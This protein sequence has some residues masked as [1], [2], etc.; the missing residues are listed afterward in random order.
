MFENNKHE[1]VNTEEGKM[2][3]EEKD[4]RESFEIRIPE[5]FDEFDQDDLFWAIP[6]LSVA[7]SSNKA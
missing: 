4:R 7:E 1:A 5:E 6:Y 3:I 2:T